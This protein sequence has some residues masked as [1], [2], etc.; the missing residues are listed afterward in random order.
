MAEA[1]SPRWWLDKL[2]PEL[3]RQA[4]D[5]AEYRRYYDGRHRLAFASKKFLEVFGGQFAAFADN[6]CGIVVDAVEERLDIEGFRFTDDPAADAGA[7]DLFQR[8]GLDVESQ[9]AHHESITTGTSALMVWPGDDGEPVITVEAA[10]EV[11]V[12]RSTVNRRTRVA[13]LKSWLDDWGVRHAHLFLPEGLYKFTS[14]SSGSAGWG[15]P[16][17]VPS[18]FPRPVVPVIDLPNRPRLRGGGR[19]EIADVIP[20]QNAVNKLVADML[21]AAEYA[22]MPQRW[23]TGLELEEDEQ[24][25][26]VRPPFDVVLHKLLIADDPAAKFGSFPP[27]DLGTYATAIELL[28]QH[29]ASQSRTPPHYFYLSGQF[30]SGESIKSAET[31]LVAKARR[32]M[33]FFGEEWEEAMRLAFLLLG[34]AR[35]DAVDAETIWADPESRTESEHIDALMKKQALGVPNQQL[36]EDA[37]YSPQQIARFP[38]MAAQ[39]TIRQQLAA[40]APGPTRGAF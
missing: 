3:S 39:D 14:S 17:F 38:A 27:A 15:D 1:G 37:G 6:W 12:R 35:A 40:G 26:Q 22:A 2:E 19:S 18:P 8:N 34:D 29:I 5:A 25:G 31:S 28:V 36:Q 13:A 24:T 32:K 4:A 33:R 7:W 10:D 9:L 21:V 23:V 11:I 30:P 16:E 20:V